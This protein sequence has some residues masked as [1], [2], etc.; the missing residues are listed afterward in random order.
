M[1]SNAIQ[2]VKPSAAPVYPVDAW[3]VVRFEG[4]GAVEVLDTAPENS[5]RGEL[6]QTVLILPSLLFPGAP[7]ESFLMCLNEA[8]QRAVC[9]RRRGFGLTTCGDHWDHEVK[10]LD[11]LVDGLD[12]E[13]VRCLALGSA[14]P[15]GL[16]LYELC[17]QIRS[18]DFVNISSS[19]VPVDAIQNQW[20]KKMIAQSIVGT[21]G[22]HMV[23]GAIKWQIRR[24][25]PLDLAR[26][27]YSPSKD[28]VIFLEENPSIVWD[29]V[30]CFSGASPKSIRDEL[31]AAFVR[32]HEPVSVPGKSGFS[33]F[34]G[35]DVP[36]V[37]KSN[38]QEFSNKCGAELRQFS[39]GGV[40]SIYMCAHEY[41]D[42][43]KS[44]P[45]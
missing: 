32:D 11:R 19:A 14:A 1:R 8:G 25:G 35:P 12:T 33:I 41:A 9:V 26:T 24:K 10:L 31:V 3:K 44:Q 18:V 20:L 30:A 43:V 13:T 28:D 23:V 45:L 16:R 36:D 34:T 7:P 37:F 6:K 27:L 39:K 2:I 29:A 40:L 42:Y 21:A 22:A 5:G 38:A 17:E 4:L 15:L